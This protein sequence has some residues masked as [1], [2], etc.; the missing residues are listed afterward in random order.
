MQELSEEILKIRT[1]DDKELRE[2]FIASQKDFIRRYASNICKRELD[3]ANDDEL[4]IAL[5]AFN[6]AIDTF[7][8][9]VG[10]SFAG[11]SRLLMRNS[12]ID[13]FRKQPRLKTV[14]LDL[15]IPGQ[16]PES[17][18]SW[19][20]FIREAEQKD[21]V[22]DIQNFCLTLEEFGL[23]LEDLVRASPRHADTRRQLKEIARQVAGE[24][25]LVEKIYGQK[26]LPI[27][28]I[29]DLAGVRR[30]YLEHWRK[31]ILSLVIVL[32][33]EELAG[34]AEYI[35]GKEEGR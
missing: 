34:L 23:N 30:K 35:S 13:Y 24:A 19:H 31:Y 11:Y 22:Y 6:E 20:V 15:D 3:W 21:R 5:M 1:G 14:S 33:R 12:L 8:P 29:Q 10:G 17:D 28:E 9:D 2:G 16:D 32:T 26:R 7:N 18:G 4:S 25:S 27:K